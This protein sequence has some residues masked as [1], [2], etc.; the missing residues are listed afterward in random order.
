MTGQG[1]QRRRTVPDYFPKIPPAASALFSPSQSSKLGPIFSESIRQIPPIIKNVCTASEIRVAGLDITAHTNH[2]SSTPITLRR[3]GQ[4]PVDRRPQQRELVAVDQAVINQWFDDSG[5]TIGSMA[6]TM[7]K[8]N[9]SKRLLY[10]WQECFAKTLRDVKPTDLIEHSIDLKPNA[11]PSYSKIP[12]YTEKERQFCDCI[13]PEMEEAGIITRASSDWGCRSRFPPKKKGSEELRVVHNYIPLNSQTI[14]PQYPMHRI[15][16]VIDTIIKPKHRCYFI[17]DASN[18][19]WAIRM[20]P[21]DEYKTGFVTPHDQYAYLQMGQGLIGAPHTYSQ[22][23]DMV[24]G[25]LPKTTTVPAQSS[26]IGDHGDWGFSLFMDDHIGAAISFE[27][28]FDFLHHYYFPRA[29]FGP[30][31]LA[32]HKTFIFTDQ[33][34]FVGFTGDKNGLRPSMKHRERIRH[35]PTPIMRAEVEAFLWLTPFLRIFI[36]GRAQHALI[37]K[38]SYL[39]EVSVELTSASS[40]KSVRKKWVEKEQ[41]TWGP[42]QRKSF[43]YIKDAVS[44]NAMGGADPA[45]QY[46]LATDASKWCLGG[47][48]FQLVDAPPGTEATHSYKEHICIIMFMSFRLEDAETR[49]DTTEREALA[50]VR[51]LAEVRWL[52]TGS[53]YPTKLYT[54]HSALE[55][56]FTQG[57]DAHGRI[58]CWMDRLTEYDYEI[59]HRPC[60]AN[61]MRIADGMSRLPAKYSQSATAIDLERMVLA[62]AHPHLRLP[63]F[64]TQLAD[65]LTPE[66][67]HQAY[68]NSNWYGKIIS[69]LL[70]GPTALDDLSSTEKKAVKRTSIKYRVT[71]QHLLY[72]ERGS[73]TAKCPLPYE[74]RSIFKWAHDEHRH[75]SN[76]LTF[77]KLRD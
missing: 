16:E 7:E 69:F 63:I 56:I 8:Q 15:E 67:S 37:I 36:P 46:H 66:P 73:E 53:E 4:F 38:Q 14:K 39:E 25:H 18:G 72:L 51:C 23:S 44:N 62:V 49:Y 20:K 35:W 22:F 34:D 50:V 3:I 60:K 45:V 42:E 64:A 48:L 58:A 43:E 47:V 40:K 1:G 11:R 5:I 13:F 28:M 12:R 68:R 26:L 24:F 70:D 41:F 9:L 59:H 2:S 31:Y 19:Y 54:D 74:I 57:S 30:V 75:F 77:H 65:V 17:T 21:G 10:T 6:N 27:A 52:V 71:D 55:S 29:I 61:I 76:Q 32:P 33:L